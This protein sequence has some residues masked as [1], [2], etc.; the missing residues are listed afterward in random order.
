MQK[1]SLL[2]LIIISIAYSDIK[3]DSFLSNEDYIAGDDGIVN[4]YINVIGNV[5]NPGTYL[6]YDGIDF[7]SIISMAGG[8]LQGSNL[9]RIV[10]Y[11]KNGEV[12]EASLQDM[13]GKKVS[14]L[15]HDTIFINQKLVSKLI[16]SSSLPSILLSILNVVLTLERTN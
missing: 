9:N 16:T 14:F 3:V 1:F 12:T 13:I 6:V 5:K 4:I 7:L 15:P 2:Y 10:V 11:S 8:Y